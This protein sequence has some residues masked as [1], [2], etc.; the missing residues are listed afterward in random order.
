MQQ[1]QVGKYEHPRV[2]TATETTFFLLLLLLLCISA[3]LVTAG[4]PTANPKR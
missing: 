4:F 3:N 2:S 1:V